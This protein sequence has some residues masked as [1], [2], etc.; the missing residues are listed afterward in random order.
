MGY[1]VLTSTFDNAIIHDRIEIA[2]KK[3]PEKIGMFNSLRKKDND[4]FG[5]P[6]L[7]DPIFNAIWA[8]ALSE[9]ENKINNKLLILISY[10]YS[11]L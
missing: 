1:A 2:Y 4:I 8:K 3:R 9:I 10:I 7:P 11:F 5:D 6:I